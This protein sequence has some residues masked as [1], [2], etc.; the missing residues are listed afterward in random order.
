MAGHRHDPVSGVAQDWSWWRGPSPPELRGAVLSC[1]GFEIRSSGAVVRREVPVPSVPLIITIDG[2]VGIYEGNARRALA[3]FVAGPDD[4]PTMSDLGTRWT[5]LQVDLAPPAASAILGVPLSE[6]A[7]QVVSLHAL[8]GADASH[9]VERLGNERDWRR[10]IRLLQGFLIDRLET[11]RRVARPVRNAW[12]ILAAGRGGTD[13][14]ELARKVGWSR[15]H[16]SARFR[17]DLGLSPKRFARILRFDHAV[18]L[19]RRSDPES[20]GR[21]A[22]RSGYFDQAHLVNDFRDLAG[23]TPSEFAASLRPGERSWSEGETTFLQD[24]GPRPPHI[25]GRH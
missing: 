1:G 13:I 5:G 11:G 22:F 16:L 12:R 7:R 9:L 23:C 8:L 19:A 6:L 4:G 17:E 15:Q 21:I 24:S 18:R 20:W 10:R 25:G 3:S 2:A 14:R